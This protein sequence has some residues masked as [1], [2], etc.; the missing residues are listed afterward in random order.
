MQEFLQ[1]LFMVVLGAQGF[2]GVVNLRGIRKVV[3]T[4]QEIPVIG[5]GDVTT[6][7]AAIHMINQTGCHGISAGRG[8]FYNP[9]IFQ[10][11]QKYLETGVLPQEPS[12][13]ERIR[14]LRRHF[15]LMVEVCGEERDLSNPEKWLLGMLNALARSNLLIM[16]WYESAHGQTSKKHYV[17]IWNG[18]NHLRMIRVIYFHDINYRP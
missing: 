7:E 8:A 15:D 18:E 12:F 17:I 3:E 16:L 11:T 10:H 1:S 2:E 6:P 13:E 14:V 4:V 5:N 9:W